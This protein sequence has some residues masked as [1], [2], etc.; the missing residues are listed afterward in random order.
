MKGRNKAQNILCKKRLKKGFR[1]YIY[2]KR[3]KSLANPA[4]YARY[5]SGNYA[6]ESSLYGAILPIERSSK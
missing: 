1:N 3:S 4:L 2:Q 5:Q 6:K